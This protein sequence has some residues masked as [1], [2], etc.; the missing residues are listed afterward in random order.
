MD[1]NITT[2]ILRERKNLQGGVNK[3]YLFPYIKYSRSQ[4]GLSGQELTTFPTTLIYDWDSISTNYT[5]NTE[6]EGGDVAWNQNFSIQISKTIVSSEVF[7]LAKKE[8]RAIIVDRLGNIRILG[9]FN[10][11]DAEITTDLGQGKTD[12]N[13]YKISFTGKEDNQAYFIKDLDSTGFDIFTI[14]NF[15]YDNGTD[16]I[17]MDNG[18]NFILD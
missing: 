7:K 9:L 12:N 4:I 8:W 3:V 11:L 16:N 17:V 5:E 6:I 10:G 1:C 2:H 18:D 15:I 14:F 13:G